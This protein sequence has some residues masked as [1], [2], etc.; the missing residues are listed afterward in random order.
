MPATKAS[1]AGLIGFVA[2]VLGLLIWTTQRQPDLFAIGCDSFG[3]ARQAAL[4]REEGL[5][6]GLGTR[7]D[8][9]EA[10]FLIAAASPS[11]SPELAK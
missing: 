8:A 1:N 5:F 10:Q 3:F 6:K 7:V 9:A 4:F 11:Y 2:A